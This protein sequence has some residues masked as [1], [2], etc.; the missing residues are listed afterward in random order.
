MMVR[1]AGPVPLK[2][3]S[4]ADRQSVGTSRYRPGLAGENTI[5]EAGLLPSHPE[6]SI[7]SG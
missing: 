2:L 1:R 7:L 6:G 4:P 5:P 3:P